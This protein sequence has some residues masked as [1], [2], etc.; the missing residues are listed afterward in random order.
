MY[1]G[2]KRPSLKNTSLQS[3]E[4]NGYCKVEVEDGVNH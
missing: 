3:N 4:S 2:I 1:L